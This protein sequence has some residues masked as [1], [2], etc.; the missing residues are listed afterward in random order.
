MC[1][2][3]ECA[4]GFARP[5]QL[6]RIGAA[7][8]VSGGRGLKNGE[9]FQAR[10]ICLCACVCVFAAPLTFEIFSCCMIW[11]RNWALLWAHRA[12]PSTPVRFA[13]VVLGFFRS[14]TFA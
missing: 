1:V 6:V 11:L 3:R 13:A 5:D 12:L 7:I 10:S 2:L 9:N 14:L 8:V 4:I